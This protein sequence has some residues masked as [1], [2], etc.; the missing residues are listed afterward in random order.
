MNEKIC[1]YTPP[2]P[3]VKTYFDMVDVS[4][5]Y[6]LK[7]IEGFSMLDFA[8]PDTE[9]AKKIKDY[10]NSKGI[11]FSCFSVYINLVGNDRA[12]MLE[13]LKGYARVAAVLGSPYLH[14][15]IANEFSNPDN[16]LP[17]KKEFFQRGV[18]AVREIYDYSQK[19]GVRTVYE[20]QGYLFN[21]IEGYGHFL[22]EVQ[23]DIGVVADFANICQVGG[24]I[25]DFIGAFSNRIVHA[26][27]KDVVLN[28]ERGTTGLKTLVGNYMHEAVIGTGDVNIK[29][30]IELLKKS[31]FTGY[32]GIE[33][34]ASCDNSGIIKENLDYINSLL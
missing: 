10:A 6:G 31:G 1:F 27:I 3:R 22:E 16:V 13:K 2:F 14:H 9:T 28:N 24:K 15:T 30:G 29:R 4:A 5:E 26:H 11:G 7:Y 20:E 33:Y 34:G 25:E 32:Y 8:V 12:E 19:L 18:E 21:G 23:R 17:Y